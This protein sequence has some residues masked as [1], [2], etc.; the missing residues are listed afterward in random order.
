MACSP[1]LG[2]PLTP[3]FSAWGSCSLPPTFPARNNQATLRVSQAR[4]SQGLASQGEWLCSRPRSTF[5]CIMKPCKTIMGL[6]G[7]SPS[8]YL[9]PSWAL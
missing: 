9:A 4:I 8:L 1:V 2:T 5:L 6:G 7:F 3:S